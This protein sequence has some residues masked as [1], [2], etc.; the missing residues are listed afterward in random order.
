MIDPLRDVGVLVGNNL[1][2]NCTASSQD[3]IVTIFF[4]ADNDASLMQS[5]TGLLFLTNVSVDMAGTYRC[6]A[7]NRLTT[8][9]DSLQVFVISEY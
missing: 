3:G 5:Q 9:T 6:N 4:S 7:T 2:L 1:T 8:V